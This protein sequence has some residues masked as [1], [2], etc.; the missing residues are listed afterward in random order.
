MYQNK[1]KLLNKL[2][3]QTPHRLETCSYFVARDVKFHETSPFAQ[4]PT[5]TFSPTHIVTSYFDNLDDDFLYELFVH[6]D[7]VVVVDDMSGVMPDGM[8]AS[9]EGSALIDSR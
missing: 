4:A 9:S 7:Q 6:N 2:F 8:G 5:S 3:C 1:V